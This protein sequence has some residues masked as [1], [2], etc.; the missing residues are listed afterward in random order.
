MKDPDRLTKIYRKIRAQ[1]AKNREAFEKEDRKLEMQQDMAGKALIEIMKA[2]NLKMIGTAHG[3]V[4]LQIKSKYWCSDWEA[5]DKFVVENNVPGL[6]ERRL[7]QK[8]TEQYLQ[9][10]PSV[11]LPG[12]QMDRRYAVLVRKPADRPGDISDEDNEG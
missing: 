10:N 4:S 11:A 6:F 9:D 7:A 5:F 8:N 1:R 3:S 12:V 2:G